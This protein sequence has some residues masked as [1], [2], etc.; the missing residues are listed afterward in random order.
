[1]AF[2][3]R[4]PI[5]TAAHRAGASPRLEPL[6]RRCLLSADRVF[7]ADASLLNVT[8]WNAN[9]SLNATPD[10]GL[11]DTAAIQAAIESILNSNARYAKPRMIYFPTGQ[12]DLSDTLVSRLADHSWSDGWRAGLHMVGQSQTGSVLRLMNTAVGFGDPT[13]PKALIKTGSE[14][15]STNPGGGGPQAFRHQIMNMTIDTGAHAGAIGIDY[16]ASN[17]GTIEDVTI[18]GAG[19]DGIRI[20]RH[21]GPALISGV[22]IDGFDYGMRIDGAQY[23]TTIENLTLTNQ[24]VV[25][26][27]SNQHPLFIRQLVSQNTVKVL[28]LTTD[29]LTQAVLVDATFTGGGG[30]TAISNAGGLLVRNLT[31][32][33]YATVIDNPGT[34]NDVAGG[35]G[36]TTVVEKTSEAVN[37]LNTGPTATLN[38][39]IKETPKF[40]DATL[41]RWL[42]VT[43]YGATPNSSS[44]DD[45]IGIQAAIDAAA[46]A[47][48]TTVYLPWG[49]YDVSQPIYLRGGISKIVGFES[50]ILK[51]SNYAGNAET[52]IFD[53]PA[54]KTI[55]MEHLQVNG[56]L[57]SGAGTLAIRHAD[58]KGYRND[59]GGTGDVFFEDVIVNPVKVEHPQHLWARQINPEVLTGQPR[60]VNK[61]GTMW[62]LG[63]KLE[64]ESTVLLNEGGTVE[65]LGAF[66]YPRGTITIGSD[67]PAFINDE[68]NVSLSFT[69]RHI[70]GIYT[71]YVKERRNGV[72]KELLRSDTAVRDRGCV[73]YTGYGYGI[74][75]GS[76]DIGAVAAAG[77]ASYDGAGTYTVSGSGTNIFG[78]SDEFRYVYKTFT[79]DGEIIARVASIQNTH[80]WA[81]TGIMFRDTLAA[82]SRN[83]AVLLTPESGVML[84]DRATAGASTTGLTTSGIAAPRW[85]KLVRSGNSFSGYHSADGI[86]WTQLGSARTVNMADTVYVGLAVT[87]R[88]DGTVC[89]STLTDVT[90]NSAGLPVEQV[91]DNNSASGVSKVGS[92][93]TTTY[94]AGFYGSDYD[95]DDNA[96]KGTKSISYGFN[97][98]PGEYEVFARWTSSSNRASNVPY[99]IVH[100]GG[101]STVFKSQRSGGGTWNSLGSYTFDTSAQVTIRTDGTNGYVIADAIR[102]VGSG[103]AAAAMYAPPDSSDG[104]SQ[105]LFSPVTIGSD[106][107]I[108]EL[109]LG[110]SSGWPA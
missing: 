60:L 18:V 13:T 101:T 16:H 88:V 29:W 22:T 48:A 57:H 95:H 82:N 61:G 10:D 2:A 39:Q 44:N 77:S 34:A 3:H 9:A 15:Q 86:A 51:K 14:G 87:S 17:R 65:L 102:I 103:T 42:N 62:L 104:A 21:N 106:P 91:L 20:T 76:S 50:N 54:G 80:D 47:G 81:R 89:T 69:M 70:S 31:S 11:D 27:N 63:V 73:L 109:L 97:V 58:I 23:G 108:E 25:G 105:P 71:V 6:E 72:W 4:R 78:N 96:G 12:Y 5:P 83:A 59:A 30:G 33:G 55:V 35:T 67:Q 1:M 68:G 37:Q 107:T 40:Y 79:G 8:N 92:W 75:S 7:P 94:T 64:G 36:T 99:D 43:T 45:A 24:T 84:Q 90:V 26:I 56:V 53:A 93:V 38:L 32:S 41:S 66:V 19:L 46:A 100:S 85:I 110:S 98:S 49:T 28:N 74:F 52:I